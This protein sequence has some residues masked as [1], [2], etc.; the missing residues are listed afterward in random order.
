VVLV[1]TLGNGPPTVNWALA[2]LKPTRRG[3]SAGEVPR[4][5]VVGRNSFGGTDYYLCPDRRD[6]P[7]IVS[8]DVVALPHR[9]SLR[10]GFDASDLLTAVIK[11]GSHHGSVIMTGSGRTHSRGAE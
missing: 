1:E 5:A 11:P 8:V 3:L 10:R 7:Q 9:L 2:G 4:G 6:N